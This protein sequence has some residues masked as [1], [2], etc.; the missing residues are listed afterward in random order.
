MTGILKIDNVI[1][2]L[3][4]K[5][6]ERIVNSWMTKVNVSRNTTAFNPCKTLPSGIP[7]KNTR[8]KVKNNN[9]PSIQN[10]SF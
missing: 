7:D 5:V 1:F 10:L 4:T 6:P 2:S 8:I 3:K 9:H